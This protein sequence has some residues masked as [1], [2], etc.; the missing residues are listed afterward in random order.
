M[1]RG[2]TTQLR[3][4]LIQTPILF[5]LEVLEVLEGLVPQQ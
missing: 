2:V 5:T 3:R 4:T 1:M